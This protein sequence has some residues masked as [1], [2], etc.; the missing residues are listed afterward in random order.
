MAAAEGLVA[1]A[2]P[3]ALVLAEGAL[4]KSTAEGCSSWKHSCSLN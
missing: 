3:A 2:E 4:K 1:P